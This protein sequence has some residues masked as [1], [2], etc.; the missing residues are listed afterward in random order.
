LGHS[1]G[2]DVATYL[3]TR[4]KR[5][6]FLILMSSPAYPGDDIILQQIQVINAQKGLPDSTIKQTLALERKILHTAKTDSGWVEL[7][8]KLLKMTNDQL[9]KLP[10]SKKKQIG[11][12]NDFAQKQVDAQLKQ[13]RNKHFRSFLT[14]DPAV[15]LKKLKI[16]VLAFFGKKDVQVEPVKNSER[17]KEYLQKSNA[18]YKIEIIPGANHLYQ[19]ANSGLPTEYGSLKPDFVPGFLDSLNTW[20]QRTVN[21][22]Q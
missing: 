19:K 15:D 14:Y 22:D 8:K 21:I 20:I 18:K 11:N 17:I 1:E 13:I 12:L 7:H 16:P 10:D 2:G 4:D 9:N 3:A 5:V 6:S